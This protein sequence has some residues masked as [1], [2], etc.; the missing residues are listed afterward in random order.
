MIILL[1]REGHEPH[2]R[3]GEAESDSNSHQNVWNR[4]SVSP[5]GY[6]C[7]H[8]G[9]PRI[10]C[11]VQNCG[12][13]VSD[14]LGKHVTDGTFSLGGPFK[15]IVRGTLHSEHRMRIKMTIIS[16]PHLP[17]EELPNSPCIARLTGRARSF[18]HMPYQAL[19][20]GLI[21]YID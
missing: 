10:S 21:E 3:S 16:V 5:L 19:N 6:S 13:N 4:M 17:C 14:T 7:L 8:M 15:S 1:G 11:G 20:A 9:T 18:A 2:Y 12:I